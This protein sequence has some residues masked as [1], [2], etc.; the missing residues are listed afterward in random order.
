MQ[1]G[2]DDGKPDVTESE[3]KQTE[4]KGRIRGVYKASEGP[5]LTMEQPRM[6]M[7]MMVDRWW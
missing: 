6:V 4:V 2:G 3:S 7:I 5:T 1:M